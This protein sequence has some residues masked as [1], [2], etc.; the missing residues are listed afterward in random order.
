MFKKQLDDLL[1]DDP[2][3]FLI[4]HVGPPL[5]A[6]S[7]DP[8]FNTYGMTISGICDGWWWFTKDN[9][10]EHAKQHGHKPIE[11]ATEVEIWRMIAICSRYWEAEY[12]EWYHKS[13]KILRAYAD[14]YGWDLWR[15]MQ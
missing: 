15:A 13:D 10:T 1:H 3:H 9:I 14:T 12:T 2:R 7:I 6:E 8:I 4:T 5:G 11:E